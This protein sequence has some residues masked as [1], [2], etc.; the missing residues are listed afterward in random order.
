MK[1]RPRTHFTPHNTSLE[2]SVIR[3]RGQSLWQSRSQTE[4]GEHQHG[5]YRVNPHRV[6][7]GVP[8]SNSITV[9]RTLTGFIP[10]KK[11]CLKSQE[12]V[13]FPTFAGQQN[14]C[15][16]HAKVLHPPVRKAGTRK[17]VMWALH[18]VYFH[19][20]LPVRQHVAPTGYSYK[21]VACVETQLSF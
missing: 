15:Y 19:I 7:G 14:P 2:H 8:D 21:D 4:T 1:R 10:R 12:V 11:G 9:L 16:N 5:K 13:G 3:V 20:P 17:V 18:S 6:V